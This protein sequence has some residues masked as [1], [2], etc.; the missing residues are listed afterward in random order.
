MKNFYGVILSNG[1]SD[2]FKTWPDAQNFI[3]TCPANAKYKGFQSRDEA[4]DFITGKPAAKTE[5]PPKTIL[6][7]DIPEQ[8]KMIAYVDGSYNVQDEIWGYGAIL[9]DAAMPDARIT[10]SGKG[11]HFACMRNVTG[12][13]TGAINAI[14][15]AIAASF[16]VI[17]IYHDYTGIACWADG[18]WNTNNGLTQSYKKFIDY[19]RQHIR[20]YFQKVEAHTGVELNEQVDRLA[21]TACGVE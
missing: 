7:E 9:F 15:A 20:I 14:Q 18:S 11:S 4:E 16:P 21:K 12:E 2:V 1:K 8:T 13:L 6:P 17:E 3:K 19:A 5:E 10:L